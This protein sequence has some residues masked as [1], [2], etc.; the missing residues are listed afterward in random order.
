MAVR[1][2]RTLWAKRNEVGVEDL[3]MLDRFQHQDS[4]YDNLRE[5]FLSKLIYVSGVVGCVNKCV[6]EYAC[7]VSPLVY[8]A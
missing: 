7:P 3:V 6:N 1:K 5:R 8:I 2:I 4:V